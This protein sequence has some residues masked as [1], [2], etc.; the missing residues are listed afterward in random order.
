MMNK[1]EIVTHMIS[2]IEEA[3]KDL[4]AAN[5]VGEFKSVRADIVNGILNELE[6]EVY[7]EN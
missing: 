7:N 1:D 6:R 2:F 3:E 5:M 4:Q